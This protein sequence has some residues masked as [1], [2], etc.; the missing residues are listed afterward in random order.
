[1]PSKR[2]SVMVLFEGHG[3]PCAGSAAATH[4]GR[5]DSTR[6]PELVID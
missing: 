4:F 6:F 2:W 5:V 3:L 1:M